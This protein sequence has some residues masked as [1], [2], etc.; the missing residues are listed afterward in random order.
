MWG[1]STRDAKL[2]SVPTIAVITVAMVVGAGIWVILERISLKLPTSTVET[3]AG[4]QV[5]VVELPASTAIASP[6][7]DSALAQES[8]NR[9]KQ[10]GASNPSQQGLL[11][12]G[13]QTEHPIRVALLLKKPG[14]TKNQDTD[15]GYETPAHWDF[16]PGEGSTKGLILSLPKR[17]L[18]LKKGDIVV[19]F[20]QDGSRRYWGPYVVGETSSPVWSATAAEWQLVLQP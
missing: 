16:D 9:T 19:A 5:S 8:T 18:T 3:L 12:V 11:R 2:K 15:T 13:N 10:S 20:A 4:S 14:Q 6:S 17:S 7:P 1:R